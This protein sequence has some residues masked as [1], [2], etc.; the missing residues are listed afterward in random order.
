MSIDETIDLTEA[1]ELD[2]LDVSNNDFEEM[3]ESLDLGDQDVSTIDFEGINEPLDLGD[4]S[5]ENPVNLDDVQL[6][7]QEDFNRLTEYMNRNNYGEQDFETYS[8]DPEW[9]ELHQR[10]FPEFHE[11]TDSVEP[12]SEVV[13]PQEDFNRL[14]EYMN[15]NN[16]GESDFDT[17]SQDP[18]WKELHQKVFPEAHLSDEILNLTDISSDSNPSDSDI[19]S[20]E[21][22]NDS[23]EDSDDKPDYVDQE[24]EELNNSELNENDVNPDLYETG[25]FYEQGI[26]EYGFEG[27]CGPTSQANAINELLGSNELNENKILGIAIDNNLCTTDGPPDAC[28]GT[29]TKQFM[30]LYEKVNED[31]GDKIVTELYEFENALSVDQMAEKIDSGSILNVAVDADELWSRP[32]EHGVNEMGEPI[33]DFA[34]DHWISVTGTKKDD[35]GNVIGFDV[36]DSGGGVSYV[37]KDKFDKICFGTDEHKVLDPTCIVVSKKTN[38]TESVKEIGKKLNFFERTFSKKGGK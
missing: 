14:S 18:E 8:Q 36:I 29:T 13:D 34:S 26:N 28:G 9:K 3:S 4:Q 20:L 25:R 27:T 19:E 10:V 32:R 17:Y 5:L 37:D 31:I 38:E 7:N 2:N 21:Q 23:L 35:L 6:N 12:V 1:T 16:Y 24:Y 22:E 33:N 15:R 30:E 11:S